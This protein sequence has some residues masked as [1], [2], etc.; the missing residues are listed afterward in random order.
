MVQL[1]QLQEQQKKH[2]RKNIDT[3]ASK[4][5]K[6]R[7]HVQEKLV[8]FMAPEPRGTWHDEMREQLFMGLFGSRIASKDKDNKESQL[9][10]SMKTDSSTGNL[11]AADGFRILVG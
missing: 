11:Q 9:E 2:R 5:R 7:Y 4:G 10:I 3:K 1:K 6:L 8:N